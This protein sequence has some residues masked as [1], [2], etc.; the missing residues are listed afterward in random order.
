MTTSRQRK[1]EQAER[2]RMGYWNCEPIFSGDV[3][4][5]AGGPSLLEQTQVP[6]NIADG[7]R[8]REA[9]PSAAGDCM[10][11]LHGKQILAANKSFQLGHW[12]DAFF[13]RDEQI[14]RWHQQEILDHPGRRFCGR[15]SLRRKQGLEFIDT[16]DRNGLSAGRCRACWNRNAGAACISV[17]YLL[18]ADRIILLGFDF[19][20]GPHELSHYHGEHPRRTIS[21]G[22]DF[23]YWL[24]VMDEVAI[25]AA[26]KELPIINTNPDSA[27]EAFPK[28]ELQ[29]VLE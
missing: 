8:R 29:E 1:Q 13:F 16:P 23:E 7:V 4:I 25:K 2:E 12:I 3:F 27:I 17:A 18:G 20:N 21:G 5:I 11:Q 6:A 9:H 28:V 19:K 14:W 15:N 22:R 26:E 24:Q 10:T